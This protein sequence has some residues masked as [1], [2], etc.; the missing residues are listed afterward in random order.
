MR[1]RT[2]HFTQSSDAL[3]YTFSGTLTFQQNDEIV[4]IALLLI[5]HTNYI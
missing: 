4:S 2:G 3:Q 5:R 1:I